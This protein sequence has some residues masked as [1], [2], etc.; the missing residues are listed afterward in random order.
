MNALSQQI[1]IRTSNKV[2]FVLKEE[3]NRNTSFPR[4]SDF[5]CLNLEYFLNSMYGNQLHG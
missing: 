4:I 2:D 1:L 5:G 3:K